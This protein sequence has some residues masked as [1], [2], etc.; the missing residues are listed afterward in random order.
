[1]SKNTVFIPEGHYNVAECFFISQ[2]LMKL[3]LCLV[4]ATGRKDHLYLSVMQRCWGNLWLNTPSYFSTM[5]C[6][7]W[8]ALFFMFMNLCRILHC[9]I[10]LWSRPYNRPSLFD[11]LLFYQLVF[12]KVSKQNVK[13]FL[14]S[15]LFIDICPALP[16]GAYYKCIGVEMW[17]IVL[18][19]IKV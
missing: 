8:A 11:Q 6:R 4:V 2:Q 14:W 3:S 16:K 17:L 1:M 5:L 13:L 19:F 12:L 7:G 18:L 10:S 9:T 15:C